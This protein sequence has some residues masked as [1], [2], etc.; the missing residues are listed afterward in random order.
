[1]RS[2]VHHAFLL[3]VL[4]GYIRSPFVLSLPIS[5][6]LALGRGL[7]SAP[8]LAQSVRLIL[9][10]A[11]LFLSLVTLIF[12]ADSQWNRFVY[13]FRWGSRC[14]AGQACVRAMSALGLQLWGSLA[15]S[16]ALLFTLAGHAPSLLP[17]SAF[18]AFMVCRVNALTP[19]SLPCSRS[20][21][22]Q[23]TMLASILNPFL[24]ILY[25]C[26]G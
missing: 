4:S 13:L 14:W 24:V 2:G 7:C 5:E 23:E 10:P 12:V 20:I 21:F 22:F 17:C 19:F 26:C 16:S 9:V 15:F 11:H 6:L 3:L 18:C 8:L 25:L 1:V